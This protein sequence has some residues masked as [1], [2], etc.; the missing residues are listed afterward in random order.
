VNVLLFAGEF[1]VV[2]CLAVVPPHPDAASE[3]SPLIDP[4][5]LD[6]LAL[7]AAR[8][9]DGCGVLV[10]FTPDSPPTEMYGVAIT[11]SESPDAETGPAVHLRGRAAGSVGEG[12]GLRVVGVLKLVE[13][14]VQPVSGVTF[15]AFVELRI[16]GATLAP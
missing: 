15:P 6:T 9:L 2:T 8:K 5:G 11:G 13:H 12:R 16:E 1:A 10:V 3:P 14:R 4:P 7:N